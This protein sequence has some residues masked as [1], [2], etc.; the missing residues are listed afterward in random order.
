M[1]GESII[2][3]ITGNTRIIY[4]RVLLGGSKL[5]KSRCHYN[6]GRWLYPAT[7]ARFPCQRGALSVR[8]RRVGKLPS[9]IFE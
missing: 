8:L 4:A 3:A 1:N 7:G 2:P 5:L 6:A 9:R